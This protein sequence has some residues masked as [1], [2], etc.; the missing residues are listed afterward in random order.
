MVD[1]SGAFRSR[2]SSWY[3]Q[4][5]TAS[6][7]PL[8]WCAICNTSHMQWSAASYHQSHCSMQCRWPARE[9]STLNGLRHGDSPVKIP[10]GASFRQVSTPCQLP[11]TL[12]TGPWHQPC[13]SSPVKV[14]KGIQTM[15]TQGRVHVSV[16]VMHQAWQGLPLADESAYQAHQAWCRLPNTTCPPSQRHNTLSHGIM[17]LHTSFRP[18][19]AASSSSCSC[20]STSRRLTMA[21]RRLSIHTCCGPSTWAP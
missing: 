7:S 16:R 13:H 2:A 20:W 3:R 6:A 5:A 10:A 17:R 12:L 18:V 9:Q 8:L 4:C 15:L 21:M 19:R 14:Y 1:H 11:A